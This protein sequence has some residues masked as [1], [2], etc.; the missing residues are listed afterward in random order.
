M[1]RDLD[2]IREIL[3]ELESSNN[4]IADS[5][6]EEWRYNAALLVEQGF[7]L[8]VVAEARSGIQQAPK[9]VVL[10][11]LTGPGHDYLKSIVD[12]T[13]WNRT[14]TKLQK[15]GGDVAFDV[16]KAIAVSESTS[17]LIGG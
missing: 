8:G 10:N 11:R 5:R 12:D 3:K 17:Y 9:R 15:L 4:G 16:V 14:K 2:L 6:S 13:I 1:K 7:V